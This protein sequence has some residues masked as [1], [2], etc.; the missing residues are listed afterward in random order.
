ME[1]EKI[2][3]ERADFHVHYTDE[4][5]ERIIDKASEMGVRVVA[6]VRRSEISDRLPE[7]IAYGREKGVTVLPGTEQLVR[8][9][10]GL[11]EVIC[12]DFDFAHQEIRR[13]FGKKEGEEKNASV[14][15]RQKQFLELKGFTFSDLALEDRDKLEELLAGK[16]LE[17]AKT[18][19]QIVNNIEANRG[20]I[21][22][23]IEEN[24]GVY[25][26]AKEINWRFLWKMFFAPGKEGYI[27]IQPQAK[28][29]IDSVHSAHGVA[30]YS[31]EGKFNKKVWDQ[32]KSSRVDGIMIW[33]G[34][35]AE[36]PLFPLIKEIRRQGFL[37]LGGSDYDPEKDD[38]QIGVGE[39]AMFISPRRY[40]D[41]ES[42][43]KRKGL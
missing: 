6:F 7:F 28:E 15:A 5:A 31:P 8:V 30:L 29:L 20:L 42:Y 37:I 2:T 43:K 26:E 10:D 35:R 32:L 11:A 9:E 13:F 23:L 14:A 16:I 22:K 41:I 27:P 38:W 1:S 33:H 12:L 19:C 34:G 36:L 40:K 24:S 17:K 3:K 18:F 25:R 39:G 21:Q 4:T